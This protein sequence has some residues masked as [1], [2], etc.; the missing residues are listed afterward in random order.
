MQDKQRTHYP[1]MPV[2]QASLDAIMM[3]LLC[4]RTVEPCDRSAV[5]D[6][7]TSH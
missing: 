4:D 2:L 3:M 6:E 1:D 7:S 5:G